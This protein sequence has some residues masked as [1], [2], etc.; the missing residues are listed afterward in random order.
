MDSITPRQ[1]EIAM[2]VVEDLTN[3]QI[4]ARLNFSVSAVR[5]NLIEVCA[6]LGVRSRVGVALA[7][8]RGE[9]VVQPFSQKGKKRGPYQKRG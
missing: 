3:E 9:F 4:A 1:A 7:M 6:R 8:E 2:L 5:K